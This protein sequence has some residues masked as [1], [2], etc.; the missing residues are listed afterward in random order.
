MQFD[1][2]EIGRKSLNTL[3]D[4]FSVYWMLAYQGQ[5]LLRK[6]ARFL[7]NGVGNPDLP[8]V[9]KDGADTDSLDIRRRQLEGFSPAGAL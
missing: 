7:Q 5:L 1:S 8:N 2:S 9:V 3:Q 4:S 6:P